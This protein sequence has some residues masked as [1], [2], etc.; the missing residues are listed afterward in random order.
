VE[1]RLH[2]GLRYGISQALLSAVS[3]ARNLTMAELIADEYALDIPN[4]K[5][6]ILAPGGE[7]RYADADKMILRRAAA[8]PYTRI[9]SVSE[10]LGVDG[11]S[12]VQYAKWLRQR[13]EELGDQTYTP[14][15]YFNLNGALG[16]LFGDNL[17]KIMA[18][19]MR[20]KMALGGDFSLCV[21]NPVIMQDSQSQI[22]TLHQ[23][24]DYLKWRNM[25]IKLVASAWVDSP[26]NI[27]S[28]IESRAAD[29]IR[30]NPSFLGSLHK[31]VESVLTCKAAGMGVV[32]GG[33]RTDTDLCARAVIHTALATRPDLVVARPGTGVDEAVSLTANE[34]ARTLALIDFFRS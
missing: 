5:I 14:I 10:Q 1:R 28:I 17:G 13:I 33:T 2:S 31:A 6:P 30:V 24:R 8:I 34:M 12:L 19:L 20:L 4:R 29:M 3:Q 26:E 16:Q 27:A 21:E 25:R 32:L 11:K 15:I 9:D 18:Y 22:K 7:D 23:L